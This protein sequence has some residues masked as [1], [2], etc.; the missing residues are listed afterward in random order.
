MF[1]VAALTL[2]IVAVV[3]FISYY[4]FGNQLRSLLVDEAWDRQVRN[5][6]RALEKKHVTLDEVCHIPLPDI[7]KLKNHYAAIR[8]KDGNWYQSHG[9][10]YYPQ[11][12]CEDGRVRLNFMGKEYFCEDNKPGGD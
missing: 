4:F 1:R 7:P 8:E 5:V 6:C 9:W 12:N 2:S 10:N 3:A 11:V